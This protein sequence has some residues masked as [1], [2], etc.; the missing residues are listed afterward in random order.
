MCRDRPPIN[1]IGYR[2]FL[3][4]GSSLILC[5]CYSMS[6][7]VFVMYIIHFL[8]F[9]TYCILHV[10]YF[11]CMLCILHVQYFSC[12]FFITLCDILRKFSAYVKPIL[13]IFLYKCT[14]LKFYQIEVVPVYQIASVNR[15]FDK[16]CPSPNLR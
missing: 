13:C 11:S 7:S 3:A 12:M 9:F 10:Q 15:F 6:Y 8:H 14:I 2:R 5:I 4:I 16:F 1:R